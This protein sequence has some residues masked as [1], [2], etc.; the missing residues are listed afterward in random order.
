[1]AGTEDLKTPEG[2]FLLELQNEFG[3]TPVVAQAVLKRSR[4]IMGGLPS[5]VDQP[6]IGQIQILAI[7][8][9]EPAGKP[10]SKCKLVKILVTVDAGKEDL[11]TLRENGII[12][13]RRVVLLRISSESL[14]QGAYLTEEDVARILRCDV[15]TARRDVKYFRDMDI[16]VPLRGHMVNTGRGQTH[17]I[18]IVRWYIQGTTHTEIQKRTHHSLEAI[19]RYVDMF[20]RI[21]ILIRR[22]LTPAAIAQVISISVPL[23]E[24]YV[25]LY[26][27]F[28]RPEYQDQISRIVE[29]MKIPK[30]PEGKKR[31][32]K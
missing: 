14:E 27:E 5:H 29:R 13:L 1:M 22:N 3:F 17:K 23:T 25:R 20:G 30:E 32:G 24:Q 18:A 28:N 16:Y 6:R 2:Q 11:K 19:S 7:S 21:V 15:R 10:L 26:L 4:E 12:G 31:R 8:A 9:E